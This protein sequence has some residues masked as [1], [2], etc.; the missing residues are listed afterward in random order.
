MKDLALTIARALT[1]FITGTL[2]YYAGR[3]HSDADLELT[4]SQC[5]YQHLAFEKRALTCERELEIAD[6]RRR[7]ALAEL[8]DRM[9]PNDRMKWEAIRSEAVKACRKEKK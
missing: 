1:L 9:Y 5:R 8:E 2:A 3:D 6:A 4:R 7:S